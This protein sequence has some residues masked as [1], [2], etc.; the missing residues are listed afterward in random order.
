MNHNPIGLGLFSFHT[1]DATMRR[2]MVKLPAD[3][4]PT[5][6]DVRNAVVEIVKED[7]AEALARSIRLQEAKP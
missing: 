6:Q 4:D 5:F 2:I 3:R 1:T 7:E